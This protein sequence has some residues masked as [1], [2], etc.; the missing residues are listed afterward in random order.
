MDRV[1]V[2]GPENQG[3]IPGHVILKTKEWYLISQHYQGEKWSNPREGERPPLHI[4]IVAIEKGAFG[5]PSTTVF[6]FTLQL[7]YIYIYIYIHTYMRVG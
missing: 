2:N 1:F 6:N 3:S 7:I 5:S 4:G